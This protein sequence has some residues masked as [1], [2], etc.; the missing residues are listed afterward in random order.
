MMFYAYV[1]YALL[2]NVL[3]FIL[4]GA[5]KRFAQKGAWRIPEKVLFGTAL[6]GGSLG[7]TLGM[8]IF[9]H[10]T[11]HWSFRIIFPM[12]LICHS[13]LSW[14]LIRFGVIQLP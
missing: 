1:G 2:M 4:M 7:G 12:L 6:L 5:D 13:L 11:K 14:F 9:R 3:A 8:Q 10:K